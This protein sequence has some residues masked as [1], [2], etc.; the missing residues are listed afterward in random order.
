MICT[1]CER[2]VGPYW[3]W[4][5]HCVVHQLCG[6]CVE[7]YGGKPWCYACLEEH[8]NP[9]TPPNGSSENGTKGETETEVETI[10]SSSD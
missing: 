4:C 3:V 1:W 2:D 7:V 10:C 6:E 9:S 8:M 5:E